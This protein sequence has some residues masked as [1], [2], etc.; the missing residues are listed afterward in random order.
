MTQEAPQTALTKSEPRAE[1]RLGD[2][3]VQIR[4]VEE[5]MR[6]AKYVVASGLAPKGDS[7]EAVFIKLQAGLELGFTP[8]RALAA[9]VVVNGRLSL[10]GQSTLALIRASGRARV[11][12]YNEGQGDDRAGVFDFERLDTGEKGKVAFTVADAK[13]AGLMGK[14]TYKGYPD[15][16]TCWRAVARGAKRYFSDI[17]FGLEVAEVARELPAVTVEEPPVAPRLQAPPADPDPLLASVVAGEHAS[18]S[19]VEVPLVDP[20][21]FESHAAADAQLVEDDGQGRLI[22]PPARR[23]RG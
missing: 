2:S 7:A 23:S 14:D 4:S 13:R 21:P 20:P 10:D 6:F 15:D 12:V 5:G 9:L 18:H 3:G 8:M 19:E 1:V 17:L 22:P 16:M 11:H